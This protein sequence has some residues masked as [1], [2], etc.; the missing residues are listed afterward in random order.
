M[1]IKLNLILKKLNKYYI[2]IILVSLSIAIGLFAINILAQPPYADEKSYL[3]AANNY[4]NNGPIIIGNNCWIGTNAILLPG[5]ELGEHVIVAAGS[6][7]TKSF[8]ESNIVIGGN[9]AKILKSIPPY[10]SKQ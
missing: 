10:F 1:L 5:V 7:V 9:P 6:V 4:I 3:A 2:Y 8:K